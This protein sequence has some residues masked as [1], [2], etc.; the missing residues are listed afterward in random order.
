MFFFRFFAAVFPVYTT[1]QCVGLLLEQRKK[2]REELERI[3]KEEAGEGVWDNDEGVVC[4]EISPNWTWAE[5]GGR[6]F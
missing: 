4:E 3:A 6:S 5:E 2:L 1:V